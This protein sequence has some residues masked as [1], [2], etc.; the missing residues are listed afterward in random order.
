[1]RDNRAY[2]CHISEAIQTIESYIAGHTFEQFQ[3][4]K[5]MIDAVVKRAGDYRGGGESNIG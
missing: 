1:M 3:T 4:N 2:L 5:M